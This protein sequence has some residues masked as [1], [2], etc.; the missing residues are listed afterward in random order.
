VYFDFAPEYEFTR[1][2]WKELFA[3]CELDCEGYLPHKPIEWF[4]SPFNDAGI[5]FLLKQG[6]KRWKIP[7]GFVTNKHYLKRIHDVYMQMPECYVIMS[8]GMC[9]EKEIWDA[10]D[11]LG[12][13][14]SILQCTTAYPTPYEEVNLSIFKNPYLYHNPKVRLFDG[15]SDHTEGIHI[16]I[17]AVA[18]GATIIEKHLTLD[19]NFSGPDHKASLEPHEFAEMVRCIRDVEKAMGS[20]IKEP[21]PSE[22][23]VRDAIRKKMGC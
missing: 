5:D 7:S 6:M 14:P 12:F 8:T 19:K 23:K 15:L 1:D 20:S 11:I 4:A 3:Y 16:P 9:T 17:A 10:F 22:L 13:E 2:E 21:T 18:M